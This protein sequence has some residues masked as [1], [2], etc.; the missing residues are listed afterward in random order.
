M[1]ITNYTLF[2]E[3]KK[4]GRIV[5]T[6]PPGTGKTEVLKLLREMKYHV[7]HEP[8]RDLLKRLKSSEWLI[9]LGAF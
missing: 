4:L 1:L 7:I 9:N 2:L 5:L 3:N 8:S 6:G